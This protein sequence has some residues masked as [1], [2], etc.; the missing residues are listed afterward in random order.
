MRTRSWPR[1]VIALLAALSMILV[2]CGGDDAVD[3][4]AADDTTEDATDDAADEPVDGDESEPAESTSDFSGTLT[5]WHNYDEG[6]PGLNNAMNVWAG[7]FEE[8]Y[9]EVSVQLEL[10]DYDGFAQRLLAAS[11]AGESFDVAIIAAFNLPELYQAG[12]VDAI[13]DLWAAYPD[14]GLFPADVIDVLVADDGAQFG[15]QAF[16]NIP[17]L[18]VNLDLLD[19]LGL[20]IP[21]T[22]AEFEAAL[23][24]ANDAGYVGVTGVGMAGGAGEFNM[25][26]WAVS[27]GWSF[28]D[29]T[30]EAM[31]DMLQQQERWVAEGWRSANDSTGFVA[32]DNFLAGD[33]LFAQDGN[34]QLSNYINNAPFEWTLITI[35]GLFDGGALGGE[36]LAIGAEAQR[37]MAWAF[38]TEVLLSEAGQQVAAEALSVPLREGVDLSSADDS[39]VP[40][41]ELVSGAVAIP[42]SANSAAI[43]TLLGDNYS[44]VIAG[45]K[46]ADAAADA[47]FAELPGL[48][49]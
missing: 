20:D 5:V 48:L 37:E 33:H 13:D 10:S 46:D 7:M 11:V 16:G 14:A 32:T 26:P 30:N 8:M 23:A 21:T 36:A 6:V 29:P 1:G 9:P 45:A 3:E 2:A 19:E 28:T 25:L 34:W 15:T 12:V 27:K 4:P 47:I 38:I 41:A 17:G 24:A 31:R 39:L 44:E 42:L 18:Y 40:F 35:P 43:S 22:E 49:E